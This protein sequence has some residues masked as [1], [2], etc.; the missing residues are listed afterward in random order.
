MIIVLYVD[1]R[2]IKIIKFI[3]IVGKLLGMR[4]W[5]YIECLIV[6]GCEFDVCYLVIFV[7]GE[8][9]VVILDVEKWEM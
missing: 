6:I 9:V 7:M 4:D 8:D 2:G 3:L 5:I 1:F